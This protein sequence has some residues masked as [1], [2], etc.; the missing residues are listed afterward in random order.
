MKKLNY[1]KMTNVSNGRF[2]IDGVQYRKATDKEFNGKTSGT[3]KWGLWMIV[4]D[5]VNFHLVYKSDVL[6]VNTQ[7]AIAL[8][9]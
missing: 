9:N 6:K 5:E 4:T 3:S 8:F 7:N 2:E 1:S